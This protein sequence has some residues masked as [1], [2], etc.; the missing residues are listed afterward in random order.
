[1]WMELLKTV[2]VLCAVLALIFALAYLLRRLKL[3]QPLAEQGLTGWRIIGTKTL[4]PKR[5]V[6]LMEVG[7]KLL[8]IGVTDRSMS[9]LME[10]SDA[11]E[12]D[13]VIEAISRKRT[14][15]S[16]KDFL[17]RAQS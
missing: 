12:R 11:A 13:K 8:L 9:A 4:A 1:M 10:I 17:K 7:T 5:Q 14:L 16:F 15:P 6:Y 2:A 3:A